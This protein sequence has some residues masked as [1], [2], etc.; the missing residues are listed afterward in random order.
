MKDLTTK[1]DGVNKILSR[2]TN[3]LKE[4]PMKKEL[5]DHAILME[6]QTMR[7]QDVN[8]GLTMAM[9]EYKVSESSRFNFRQ[10]VPEVP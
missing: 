6:D 2:I 1:V 5:R 9:E 4:V 3:S 8:T 10:N 7:V